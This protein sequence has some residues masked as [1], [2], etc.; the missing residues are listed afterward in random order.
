MKVETVLLIFIYS[1]EHNV[2]VCQGK[3]YQRLLSTDLF[4]RHAG[5]GLRLHLPVG[6]ATLQ[7]RTVCEV[8]AILDTSR[9][10]ACGIC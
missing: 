3:Q 7:Y 10:I 5:R 8:C 6:S 4:V 2:H 1:T 9:S